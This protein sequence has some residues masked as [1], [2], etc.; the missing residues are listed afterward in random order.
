MSRV[1]FSL[2]LLMIVIAVIGFALC[3]VREAFFANTVYSA[4]YDESRFRQARVGMTSADVEA[5]MGPPVGKI[6]WWPD[7][8]LVCW[9]YTA[10]RKGGGD[11]WRRDVFMKDGKVVEVMN[12]YKID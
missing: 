6:P 5:L 11:Y 4:G 3:T 9:K 2:R 8:D 1:R 7:Q 12:W 10:K